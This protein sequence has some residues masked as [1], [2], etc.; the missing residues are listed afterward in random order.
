MSN[1]DKSKVL[2]GH[3]SSAHGIK[4]EVTIKS[5]TEAPGDIAAY[6][7]LSDQAGSRQFV[8]EK[9]RASNKGLIAT[10]QGISDRTAAEAL[11]GTGLFVERS[12]LP[13]PDEDDE[14]YVSDLIGL[15]AVAPDGA[16]IGQ[17]IAVQNFG[18]GD[19]LEIRSPDKKQTELIPF[20]ERFVP[21]VDLAAGRVV[22]EPHIESNDDND[23]QT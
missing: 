13:P 16:P 3:I 7:P 15:T 14:F 4:G 6:G 8:I 19:L 21:T 1:H 2:L 23:V 22:I 17:I 10:L 11:K 12:A 9:V 20:E 18:A 5:Y